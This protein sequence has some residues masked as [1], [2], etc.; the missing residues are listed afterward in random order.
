M[1]DSIRL[2]W[3]VRCT[4][5]RSAVCAS[6]FS[7][8]EHGAG[9]SSLRALERPT[10]ADRPTA[11]Q[12]ATQSRTNLLLH[13]VPSPSRLQ[14]GFIPAYIVRSPR[15]SRM[16]STP[17][18]WVGSM[19]TAARRVVSSTITRAHL[20]LSSMTLYRSARVRTE[21]PPARPILHRSS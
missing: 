4:R 12:R 20:R 2:R 15:R 9:S 6:F 13:L 5:A 1:Q 10:R 11:T 17:A 3:Y 21:V 7:A 8:R 14:V 16:P 18:R 19:C